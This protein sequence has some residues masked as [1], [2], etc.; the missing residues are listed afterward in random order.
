LRALTTKPNLLLLGEPTK[1]TRPIHHQGYRARDIPSR[2]SRAKRDSAGG[3][4]SRF[5]A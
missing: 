5:R 4:I 2:A 3:A 1:G